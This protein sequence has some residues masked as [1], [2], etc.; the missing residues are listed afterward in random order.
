MKTFNLPDLGEG[1]PEAEIVSWHVR[2]GDRVSADDLYKAFKLRRGTENDPRLGKPQP[3]VEY[4][5][6]A[7]AK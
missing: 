1:L 7:W 6:P 5:W 3:R 4:D 2:P